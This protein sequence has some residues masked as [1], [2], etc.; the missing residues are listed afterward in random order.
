MMCEQCLSENLKV[1][2]TRNYD[3]RIIRE[4][5]CTECDCVMQTLEIKKAVRRFD[6]QLNKSVWVKL[7]EYRK[8][9]EAL[10]NNPN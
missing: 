7:E 2:H 3:D 5:Y 1:K 9:R 10:C 6:V 4:W 8:M